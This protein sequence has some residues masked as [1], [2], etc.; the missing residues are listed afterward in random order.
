MIIIQRI[1]RALEVLTATSA[2]SNTAAAKPETTAETKLSR[3][4]GEVL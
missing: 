4:S 2:T 1:F 3:K